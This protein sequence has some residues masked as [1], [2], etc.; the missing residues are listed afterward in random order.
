MTVA[1]TEPAAMAAGG[2]LKAPSRWTAARVELFRA[3]GNIVA[4]PGALFTEH[5]WL[6]V[7]IGQCIEPIAYNPLADALPPHELPR[8]LQHHRA[9]AQGVV[10]AMPSHDQFLAARAPA[11]PRA[12]A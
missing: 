4:E 6:Q 1:A 2:N 12:A 8:F 7:L 5:G 10:A 3:T 11:Q 9:Q